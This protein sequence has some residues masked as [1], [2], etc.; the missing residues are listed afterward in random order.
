MQQRMPSEWLDPASAANWLEE[1]RNSDVERHNGGFLIDATARD[2]WAAVEI[3]SDELESLTARLTVGSAG[4]VDFRLAGAAYVEGYGQAFNLDRPRRQVDVPSLVREESIFR[5][6]SPALAGRLRSAIDLVAPLETGA[7]GAAVAGG[8][9]A[10]EAILAKPNAPN[11]GAADDLASLIACS[12]PRAELTALSYAY[13][14]AGHDDQLTGHLAAASSNRD[15]SVLLADA[16]ASGSVHSFAHR[17]DQ[18]AAERMKDLMAGPTDVLRR[19]K[20][21]VQEPIRRLYRQ[22][23]LVL[24]A[25]EMNSVAMTTALR[26]A[27]PLVGAGLDRL[28]HD[29]LV[30]GESEPHRLVAR[31]NL[32][33]D[34]ASS[35]GG[36][37]IVDLLGH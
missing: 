16:I 22:R 5:I 2:P 19:I 14:N 18:A 24:H 28:V 7:P 4:S 11:I 34:M 35:Q 1:N 8:W 6:K 27:P 36:P 25:G 13:E 29:A 3:V 17:S 21:Y 30:L 20:A 15:R 32:A 9:A 37:H 10:I 26:T 33:I 31:A 23:N 12:F